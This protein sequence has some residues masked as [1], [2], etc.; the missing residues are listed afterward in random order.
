MDRHRL[1]VDRARRA[2]DQIRI[3]DRNRRIVARE[4]EAIGRR[5]GQRVVQ[6]DGLE[7]RLQIVKAIRAAAGDAEHPVDLC[8]GGE[9]HTRGTPPCW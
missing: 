5:E 2:E 8:V 4:R 3:V 6:R 7:D 9:V 1:G